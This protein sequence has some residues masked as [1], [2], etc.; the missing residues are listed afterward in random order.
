DFNN[1]LM[2]YIYCG[3]I[4]DLAEIELGMKMRK[5]FANALL[6][7]VGVSVKD[8]CEETRASANSAATNSQQVTENLSAQKVEIDSV[9]TAV[10]E[11][12]ASSSE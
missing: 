2:E 12:Q 1:P 9:A 8:S 10:N 4:N 5:Q 11:M 3:R 7:R 6:G